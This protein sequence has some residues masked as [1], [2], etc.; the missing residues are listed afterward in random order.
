MKVYYSLK[1]LM[2]IARLQYRRN[3]IA[4]VWGS[5]ALNSAPAVFGNAMPKAGSH[6]LI[7]VLLGLTEVGPF[8]NPGFPPVNR[9]EDNT[10]LSKPAVYQ[11]IERM[12]PG[13]IRYGYLGFKEPFS[14]LLT[15]PK[16]ATVFI[17]RDPRDLLVSHVFYAVDM[18]E[19][20]GMHD[21]YTAE[22]ENMEERLNVAI[23]GIRE[24]GLGLPSVWDRYEHNLAWIDHPRVL[25]I[26]FEDVILDTGN[27]LWKIADY[28]ASYGVKFSVPRDEVVRILKKAIRPKE[29]GTFRKGQPGNWREHFS[30]ENKKLFKE[31]TGDLLIQLGYEKNHDW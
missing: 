12:R 5:D 6:L 28:I 30:E 16:Y 27:T 2:K 19:E 29:S 20:H 26:R 31:V 14:T 1:R 23:E 17:Y 3:R 24:P 22:L 13:D 8:V 9:F 21:Y 25:S 4:R 18:H 11:E 7:Q 15:S 10:R